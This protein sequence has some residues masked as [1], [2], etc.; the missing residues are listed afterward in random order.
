M[1][2][3]LDYCSQLIRDD[4]ENKLRKAIFHPKHI[5]RSLPFIVINEIFDTET[6]KLR[7]IGTEVELIFGGGGAVGKNVIDFLS[8]DVKVN[9]AQF[10]QKTASENL[11]SLQEEDLILASGRVIMCNTLGFPMADENGINRFRIT[12]SNYEYKRSLVDDQHDLKVIRNEIRNMRFVNCSDLV[13][14]CFT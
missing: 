5:S 7:L 2:I 1:Q 11:V 8:D 9:A 3:F 4:G 14:H 6:I 13:A 12:V 10:F